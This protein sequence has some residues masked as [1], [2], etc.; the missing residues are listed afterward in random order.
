M[1]PFASNVS[2]VSGADRELVRRGITQ[3]DPDVNA[4]SENTT[5]DSLI[6]GDKDYNLPN[7]Y[8]DSS[9]NQQLIERN[10]QI[11]FNYFSEQGF[12]PLQV[13]G[14]MGNIAVES[15][16]D[17][18]RIQGRA[19]GDGSKNPDDAGGGG[20]GLIQWTP[21][22]KIKTALT[23]A[24]ID[25]PVWNLY[26]QLDLI[27]GHMQNKPPITRGSF[28]ID[29]YNKL[30]TIQEVVFYFEDQIEGA[31]TPHYEARY[32]AAGEIFRKYGG[33]VS[34]PST[35]SDEGSGASGNSFES[36][37]DCYNDTDTGNGGIASA[38]GFTFPLKTTKTVIQKGTYGDGGT[39]W[40]YK[41]QTNCHHHYNAADVMV[42]EGTVVVAARDGV[43]QRTNPGNQSPNNV[44]IKT[45]KKDD[46]AGGEVN[47]Y[48]HMGRNTVRVRTG[49]IVKAG[50]ILGAVGNKEDAF[51]TPPHLHFDMLPSSYDYRVSCASAS[52]MSYPFIEVQPA[53]T[54][55]YEKLPE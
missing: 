42:P 19:I 7:D 8:G 29:D 17:P 3:Y 51:N 38:N 12:P 49:K 16:F 20:Y 1:Q 53:M 10:K 31:G 22:S 30:R 45:T 4:C 25:T 50:D 15:G 36:N 2:A 52:C 44:T 43:V 28:N 34:L 18:E 41:A 24:A 39:V 14:I 21:G 47:F 46:H 54:A 26:T 13:A 27:Y 11:M 32:Q 6:I 48:Q 37:D 9:K 35:I 23:D 40:C 5:D 55:S 33:G